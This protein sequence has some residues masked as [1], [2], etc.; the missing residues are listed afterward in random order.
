MFLHHK[1]AIPGIRVNFPP[2]SNDFFEK[3]RGWE[4]ET[5]ISHPKNTSKK[6][7]PAAGFIKLKTSLHF[8][9][10]LMAHNF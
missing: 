9:N 1:K 7:A 5:E 6:S 10:K 8:L 3:I 4:V 2:P